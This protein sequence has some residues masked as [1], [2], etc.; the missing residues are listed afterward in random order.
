MEKKCWIL[1]ESEKCWQTECKKRKEREKAEDRATQGH[2]K[3][4]IALDHAESAA[5]FTKTKQKVESAKVAAL[6]KTGRNRI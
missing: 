5:C 4:Q 3:Q 1:K 2:I 6:L